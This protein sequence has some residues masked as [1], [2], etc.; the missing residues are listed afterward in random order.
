M[1]SPITREEFIE[2]KRNQELIISLLK[3]KEWTLSRVAEMSGRTTQAVRDWLLNNAEP[4]IDFYKKNGKIIV[5]EKVALD[6]ITK[7]R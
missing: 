1:S 7:R 6:Y 2:L 4:D 5:S 3:P